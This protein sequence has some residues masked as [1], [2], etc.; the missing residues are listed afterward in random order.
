[1][2][3]I[4]V[5]KSELLSHLRTNRDNHVEEYNDALILYRAAL[6][7]AFK[8]ALKK[9]KNNEDVDHYIK[10]ERPQ[11]YLDSYDN[12]IDMLIWSTEDIIELD[13]VE[14]K[15]YVRDEWNWKQ[16]FTAVARSYS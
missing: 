1:M 8:E 4:K 13:Q 6:T 15:Q 10:L 14:F 16:A 12:A 9:A 5:N 2:K 7:E 11:N 3:T